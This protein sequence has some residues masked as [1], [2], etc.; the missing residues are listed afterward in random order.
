MII[1][2]FGE[3]GVGKD[4][5]AKYLQKEFTNNG[6][7]A[8]IVKSYTT[9]KKREPYE[10]THIFVN[11]KQHSKIFDRMKAAESVINDEYYWT[12]CSQFKELSTDYF[13]YVIDR[14]GAKQIIDK[15]IDETVTIE[16]SRPYSKIA[17]DKRRKDRQRKYDEPFIRPN[18]VVLNLTTKKA[19]QERARQIAQKIE[20]KK[21]QD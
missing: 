6:F 9:R 11:R 4:T 20:V 17:V 19:L 21:C 2:I 16:I 8:E 5:F 15:H 3:F 7:K 10:D 12:L 13:I 1:L 14:Y 18:H